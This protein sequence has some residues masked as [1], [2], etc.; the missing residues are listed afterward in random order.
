M[1]ARSNRRKSPPRKLSVPRIRINWR[2]LL[3]PPLAL[4]IVMGGLVAGKA[5]LDRPVRQLSIEGEFRRVS[6][7]QIEAA[8]ASEL[9]RGFLSL[10]LDEL[11]RR[12]EQL[13]WVDTVRIGR[14]WPD[15]LSVS[16]TEHIAAARWGADGLLNVR[17]ELFTVD[18]RHLP[19]ELPQLG[20]PPG[21]ERE[22]ATYYLSL[23][24]RLAEAGM[25]LES[26]EMDKRGA[27][28]FRL[29]TGQEIRI[30]RQ[31]IAQRIDRFFTIV[32]PALAAEFDGVDYVDLRYTNGFTVG[33]SAGAEAE[34]AGNMEL[35]GN[36]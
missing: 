1:R 10:D 30:G 36:G 8:L 11:S 19:A 13:A 35:S 18:A 20:G 2:A 23:R 5:L 25:S 15:A 6:P 16:V 29:S 33:W 32:A 21:S 31:E 26:L 27:L 4:G 28:H 22:V 3:L 14:R 24:G 12:L 9:G 34:L 17:G 7:L